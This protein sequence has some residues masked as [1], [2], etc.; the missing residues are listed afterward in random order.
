MP[1]DAVFSTAEVQSWM[2]DSATA[3]GKLVFLTFDDGPNDVTTPEVLDILKDAGALATFFVVGREVPR[4]PGTLK[5][6]VTE[7]HKI[8][9]H[10]M[11]HDYDLL[12]PGRSADP[13]RVAQEFDDTMQ[14]VRDVL[15]ADFTTSAWRYPGGHMSWNNMKTCDGLLAE[16]GATWLDW[17][18]L[19]GDAEPKSRRPTSA[20]AMVEM[21][22]QPIDGGHKVVVLLAHDSLDK[23]LTVESLPEIID[24]YSAAGYTFGTVV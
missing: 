12:Y 5:R 6:T 24:A 8:A 14:A 19:T 21:A 20:A 9:L 4:A 11:T 10:S 13:E 23:D 17:N 1:A 3:P 16:R 7:G 2:K 15:G 18:A 22:T